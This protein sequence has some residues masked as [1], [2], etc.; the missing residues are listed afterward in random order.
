[1]FD[2]FVN[3]TPLRALRDTGCSAIIAKRSLVRPAD[4]TGQLKLM[5]MIDRTMLRV[6]TAMCHIRSPMYTGVAEVLCLENPI[7]D[8]IVGNV[9]GVCDDM[10]CVTTIDDEWH[11]ERCELD[12]RGK[13]TLPCSEESS[14][15]PNEAVGEVSTRLNVRVEAA[16][17]VTTR[18]QKVKEARSRE[19]LYVP[20][21]DQ[22]G[23]SVADFRNKQKQD[24]SLQR[25]WELASVETDDGETRKP[26]T[27]WFRVDGQMLFRHQKGDDGEDVRRQLVVPRS[28]RHQVMKVGH[29]TLLSGHQGGKKTLDRIRRN[30]YW[31]GIY[32]DVKRFC[33]SCDICQRTIPRGTV[34]KAPLQR[35]PVVKVPFEKV[36]IDLIGPLKPVSDRGHR[37]IVTL[38]DFTT[39]YPEAVALKS[40]DTETVAEPLIG[41]FS[42]VGLPN[43]I[44]N[45]NGS[46]FVSGLMKEVARLLSISWVCS[47]PYH[48]QSNGLCEKWNGSLKRML[49]RMC[50]ERTYD[51]D[52]YLEPL[53]FAYREAPQE[54][55]RFSPFELLYGRHVRG[56]MD[57][58]RELWTNEQVDGEVKN[59]YRYIFDLRNR[60]EDTCKLASQNLLTAQ[61]RHKKHFDKRTKTRMLSK[62]DQVLVMLP[63]DNNKLLMRWKGPYVVLEK[64]GLTDYRIQMGNRMKVFHINMLKQYTQRLPFEVGVAMS[65]VDVVPDDDVAET[66][67]FCP[68][69]ESGDDVV[70]ASTLTSSQLRE[71]KELVGRYPDIFSDKPGNTTLVEH[72]IELF[73][74]RPVR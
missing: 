62:N 16:N 1:M 46:Q 42:R 11:Q 12:E 52:R 73:D 28:L 26:T 37:W 69:A 30:F 56:P 64:V 54:S 18:A 67:E 10:P 36:A 61:L 50:A 57:I 38:V 35:V 66:M 45:D 25:L 3:E 24:A 17:A 8:L 43:E 53:M 20:V 7:C 60:I 59:V 65:F 13:S 68:T 21:I 40:I 31:P 9:D 4:M 47:S 33:A 2:G 39:R 70:L 19:P 74:A 32:G 34:R 44:L 22:S 48:P 14:P 6:P 15:I 23:I 51:W 71:L 72:S 27:H 49:R 41:I 55:T 58:L 63:T 29:E 5:V